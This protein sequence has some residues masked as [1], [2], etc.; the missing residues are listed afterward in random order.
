[1]PFP[2]RADRMRRYRHIRLMSTV[3]R[4]RRFTAARRLAS[5]VRAMQW[6]DSVAIDEGAGA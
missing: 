2:F 6:I 1:M 3:D 5:R 4:P